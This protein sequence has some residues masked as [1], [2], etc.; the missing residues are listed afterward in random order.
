MGN[1]PIWLNQIFIHN[2]L[3]TLTWILMVAGLAWV[4]G[5]FF[6]KN[7]MKATIKIRMRLLDGMDKFLK[8][9]NRLPREAKSPTAHEYLVNALNMAWADAEHIT[10]IGVIFAAQTIKRHKIEDCYIKRLREALKDSSKQERKAI[11]NALKEFD[12]AIIEHLVTSTPLLWAMEK[13][14]QRSDRVARINRKIRKRLRSAI[15]R[16]QVIL[17]LQE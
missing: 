5:S 10:L 8:Q 15:N 12:E 14:G 6:A 2:A 11:I 9:I 16:R 17:S 13:I 4:G 7:N 3:E 1:H